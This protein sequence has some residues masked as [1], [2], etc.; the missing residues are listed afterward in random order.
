[1]LFVLSGILAFARITEYKNDVFELRIQLEQLKENLTI[2]KCVSEFK[3]SIDP[4]TFIKKLDISFNQLKSIDPNT[5][6]GLA[7]LQDLDLRNNN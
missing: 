6:N 1:M 3:P 7:S 5:F 2:N 4:N